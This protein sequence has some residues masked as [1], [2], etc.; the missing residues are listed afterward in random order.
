MAEKNP[1]LVRKDRVYTVVFDGGPGGEKSI[2]HYLNREPVGYIVISISADEHV[3]NTSA[4]TNELL[5]VK[6]SGNCT[7]QL[8]IL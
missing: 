2:K 1:L 4:H 7:A 8:L 3:Y 5:K 6:A